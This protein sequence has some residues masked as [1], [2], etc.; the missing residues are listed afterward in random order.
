MNRE[1]ITYYVKEKTSQTVEEISRMTVPVECSLVFC[2]TRNECEELSP[3]LQAKG[4][5]CKFYHGGMDDNLRREIQSKWIDGSLQCLV[6]TNAFGMGIN[7]PNVR[8][9]IHFS[10]PASLEDMC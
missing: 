9:A 1:N 6:C 4:L 3:K 10:I 2:N 8:L 7:K 5:Q